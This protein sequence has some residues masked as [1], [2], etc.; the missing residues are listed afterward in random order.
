VHRTDAV[1]PALVAAVGTVEL[2]GGGYRPLWASVGSFWLACATLVLRRRYP[3][4]MPPLVTLWF[5]VAAAAGVEV[6]DP[7]SWIVPM[8]FAAFAAGRYA[9][10]PAHIT[11]HWPGAVSVLA[12]LAGAYLALDQ[13]TAFS[14]DLLFGL[15]G[16][17]LPW[18]L[19]RGL[20]RELDRSASVAAEA[21]RVRLTREQDLQTAASAERERIARE[22]HDVL[23]HSLSLMVVQSS[24]A[25]DLVVRDP[26]A[27]VT[28]LRAVQ[29]SG[30]AALAE[31]GRL[32]RLIRDD[33]DELG[34]GPGRGL[35]HLVVLVDELGRS[36]LHVSLDADP[37]LAGR[38]PTGVELSV[39]RIVQEGLT[40]ALK[41]APGSP[42][43]VRLRRRHDELQV[44]VSNGPP[45]TRPM[46]EVAGGHGLVGVRERVALFGG[47]LSHGVTPDGGFQLAATLPVTGQGA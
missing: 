34:L 21:E 7:A 39:Y 9:G 13:L 16:S 45:S 31:T 37:D 42:V 22:L 41:H 6:G 28:A 4:A 12:G 19:G 20:R 46:V 11:G 1:L 32:L 26:E 5:V 25:E 44:E 38:L 27:A 33:E 23:A 18:L 24:L 36:G 29:D 43:D 2:V 40:N 15:I 8:T 17:V 3:L 30:R 35:A 14:P 47:S 10:W